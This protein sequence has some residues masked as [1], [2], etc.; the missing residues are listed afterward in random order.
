MPIN[1]NVFHHFVLEIEPSRSKTWHYERRSTINLI[2]GCMVRH[3]TSISKYLKKMNVVIW[4]LRLNYLLKPTSLIAISLLLFSTYGFAFYGW[5]VYLA[6]NKWEY[7]QDLPASQ[8]SSKDI[9]AAL[10]EVNNEERMFAVFIVPASFSVAIVLRKIGTIV[11]HKCFFCGK[12]IKRKYAKQTPDH[13]YWYHE[14][15]QV[16]S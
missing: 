4:K 7:L 16:K 3:E 9:E 8:R 11:P 12:W 13:V 15:C 5:R 1:F 6:I 10:Q 14:Q 2:G